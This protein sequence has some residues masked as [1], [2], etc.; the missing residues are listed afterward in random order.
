MELKKLS[1]SALKM[2]SERHKDEYTAHYTYRYR[3]QCL[4][5]KG[6]LIAAAYYEKEAQDEL[7][8]AK[9]LEDYAAQWNVELMFMGI[10]EP[11]EVDKLDEIII[12][13]YRLEYDLL[14][15]YKS[16]AMQCFEDG[17]LEHFNFLQQFVNIQNKS[18]GE[19]ADKINMLNL[20]DN[21][22]PSWLFQMEEKLFGE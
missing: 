8:H 20:F 18:V 16:T 3:S 15:A 5:G 17:E 7:S 9:M 21:S 19:Y 10:D 13:S 14:G 6:F 11:S 1:K 4:K 12:D 2:L 22:D